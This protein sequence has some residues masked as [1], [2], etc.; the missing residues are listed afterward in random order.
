MNTTIYDVAIIGSGPSGAAAAFELSK[1]GIS[2]VIIEKETLPRY[3]PCGGGIVFRGRQ[4]LPFDITPAVDLE[5]YEVDTYFLKDNIKLTTK[6]DR[7]II[8]MVMRDAFDNLLVEKA[9][10]NGVTILQGH[11]VK[12]ISFGEVQL[13]HTSEGTI[14]SKFI[15]AADGALSPVAKLAGWKETRRIVPALEYEVYVQEDDLKRLSKS[16]RFDIDAIPQGYGWCFPKKGHL[17]I[18]VVSLAKKKTRINLKTFYK[19]YL[20]TLEINEVIKEDEHGYVIPVSPRKDTFT[21]KNVFLTGD[22]A[23][24]ADPVVA[25]GISNSIRSGI[26]AAQAIIEAELDFDR[27]AKLY[28]QKLDESILVEIKTGA[29]FSDF[30][31]EREAARNFTV[32]KKGQYLA[33]YLTDIFTGDKNY[34]KDTGAKLWR[35]V[36]EKLF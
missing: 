10:Q 7:P 28:A 32:K 19:S 6:R 27:A 4:L 14:T 5:F 2:V 1:N 35:K 25:E 9:L 29:F 20:K 34:P 13:I 23:G 16:V 18:G 24:F 11:T 36:R 17:S 26:L 15:I 21:N 8:T 30:L 3:K 22:A 12:N 31:Y 33:E